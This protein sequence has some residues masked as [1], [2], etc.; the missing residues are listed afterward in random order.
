M[1]SIRTA[2]LAGALAALAACSPENPQLFSLGSDDGGPDEFAILPTKPLQLPEDLA[3][4][5]PPVP[6]GTNLADPTPNADAVAALGG[7]GGAG[8]TG[9]RGLVAY[10]S[11]YGVSPDIRSDLAAADL[12]FRQERPGRPLE[13]LFSV[14]TYYRAYAGQSLD[15]HAEL[16]RFRAAGVPTPAAPPDP[17]AG[18]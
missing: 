16:R 17:A 10:V 9:D 11:R 2:I 1:A 14:T 8:A 15:Q 4:L 18:P 13:R 12:A 6:E 5:P 7:R 3:A